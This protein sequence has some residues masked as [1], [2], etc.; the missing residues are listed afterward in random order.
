MT[1]KNGGTKYF[2]AFHNEGNELVVI[3]AKSKFVAKALLNDDFDCLIQV[4]NSEAK[5][6]INRGFRLVE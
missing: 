5:R 3:R 6:L 1:T 2:T 4:K